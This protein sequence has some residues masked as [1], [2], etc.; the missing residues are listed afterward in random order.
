MKE[1]EG[2]KAL[3][4]FKEREGRRLEDEYPLNLQL[5]IT[6]T[7]VLMIGLFAFVKGLE[8]RPYSSR[9]EFEVLQENVDVTVKDV[10]EPPPPP[11]PKVE[12]EEATSEE[13]AEVEE[14]LDIAPTTEFNELEAP[15]PPVSEETFEFW[16][17]E[18]KPEVVK[19]VQPRYP[20][21]ARRAGIE[22]QVFV[23]VLVGED[24]RVIRAEIYGARPAEV[25]DVLGPAA[26]EAAQQFVFTPGMQRDKPVK[27][28]VMI[29]FQFRLE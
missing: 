1:G 20:E 25:K 4:A 5:G 28:W 18:K 16:A 15:P 22:G 2:M 23:R 14:K 12:V 24:G 9:T 7:L 27:V 21:L 17:V 19:R 8:V 13:E 3:K 10:E 29:P 11:K 26:L 6:I